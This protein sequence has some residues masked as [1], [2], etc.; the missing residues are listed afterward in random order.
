[1]KSF[2]HYLDDDDD[3]QY[4]AFVDWAVII[5]GQYRGEFE[6]I[7]ILYIL[8]YCGQTGDSSQIKRQ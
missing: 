2:R 4:L 8:E 3:G 5:H 7:I 6:I 1:M